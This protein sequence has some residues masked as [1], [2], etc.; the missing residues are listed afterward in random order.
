VSDEVAVDGW[1]DAQLAAALCAVNPAALGGVRLRGP[2]D[3]RRDGWLDLLR[4]LLPVDVVARRV[5]HHVS[6]GRLLGEIDLVATLAVGRPVA[7]R[8]LLA[9][10]DGGILLVAMAE[11]IAP[12]TAAHL[13]RALD[14]Q[15]VAVERDGLGA[16]HAAKIGIVALDEG[17]GP[18]EA[19]PA[20]LLE[21]LALQVDVDTLGR[22]IP[23][24]P[25]SREDI[26]AARRRLPRVRIS[27]RLI[28]ALVRTAAALGVASLRAV[29]LAAIAA[30]TLAALEGRRVATA[31]D[32]AAAARLVL[33]VRATRLPVPPADEP[34]KPDVPEVPDDGKS[35]AASR[36]SESGADATQQRPSAGPPLSD[37]VLKA[38]T[39]AIPR[40]LLERLAT[41]LPRG[42][43]APSAGA[44]GVARIGGLRGRPAGVRRGV[45]RDDARL[46]IID[47]LR[48]AAP[49][50]KV[51]GANAP[52]PAP[53]RIA[54]RRED[55]HVRRFKP[56]T[57]TT[58]I[59]LVD[60]SGSAAMHRLAE[61]K[62]AVEL[63]LADCYARRDRVALIAFRG[64][65]AE[66]VLA[67]TRSLVRAKRCLAALPAGGGTPFAAGVDA[68]VELAGAVRRRGGTPTVVILSD[69]RANIARDG[70]QGRARAE[71]DARAAARR[72]RA[73][74][75]AMLFVDTSARPQ[76]LAEAIAGEMRAKYL[77]LPHADAQLLSRAARAAAD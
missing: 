20:A 22:E 39:A 11:R 32:A 59:F 10:S 65:A 44:S 49:W 30:R 34:D 54:V 31:V 6:D 15:E 1:P 36:A 40:G 7:S 66:L 42:A 8:G 17:D 71:A 29:T 48:A 77:P 26:D 27:V 14:W 50:Q 46:S 73:L 25:Y 67:P 57:E 35:D 58:T 38:A 63:L 43:R 47:T 53:R 5:P 72:A 41:D 21:R 61:A 52:T 56:R 55:L 33:A 62:G 24:A 13:A 64:R 75:L 45:P 60:A 9:A 37:V 4:S 23:R 3:P 18:E 76:P 12:R 74:R 51:R 16:L 2:P 68:A 69:G 28:A 70:S 19:P